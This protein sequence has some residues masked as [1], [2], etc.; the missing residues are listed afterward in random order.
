MFFINVSLCKEGKSD[1]IENMKIV[2]S[3]HQGFT[4]APNPFLPAIKMPV[5]KVD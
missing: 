4:F 3:Q 5:A 1:Y 2:T